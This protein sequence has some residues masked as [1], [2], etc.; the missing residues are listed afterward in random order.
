MEREIISRFNVRIYLLLFLLMSI[1]LISFFA[2]NL[3]K[4]FQPSFQRDPSIIINLL[5][6]SIFL[7]TFSRVSLKEFHKKIVSSFKFEQSYL[8]I[9]YYHKFRLKHARLLVDKRNYSFFKRK[10]IRKDLY[11]LR[12][13]SED[14]KTLT[15]SAPTA[16]WTQKDLGNIK[17]QLQRVS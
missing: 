7:Y 8:T 2:F 3:L 13:E 10:Y 1:G 16:F 9:N 15:I 17:R 5:L 4:S 14:K 6:S 12:F 11:Y